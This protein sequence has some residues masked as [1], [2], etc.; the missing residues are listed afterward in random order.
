MKLTM[1]E[2]DFPEFKCL[3]N[4]GFLCVQSVADLK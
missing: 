3:F 4:T 1:N 2:T